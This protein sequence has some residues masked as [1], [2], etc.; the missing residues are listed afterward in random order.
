MVSFPFHDK[1]DE[2]FKSNAKWYMKYLWL[3]LF[4]VVFFGALALKGTFDGEEGEEKLAVKNWWSLVG[5]F[6]F[7]T[8]S[9]L[10]FMQS[11]DWM[12]RRRNVF[13]KLLIAVVSILL[14]IV[15]L[16]V[17]CVWMMH[18]FDI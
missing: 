14:L 5:F 7:F 15:W 2:V 16:I 4:L 9:L 17:I 1:F 3:V 6:F 12:K 8:G 18:I 10:F 11:G 13:L